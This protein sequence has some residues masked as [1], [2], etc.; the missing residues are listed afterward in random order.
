MTHSVTE[1]LRTLLAPVVISEGMELV[2]LEYKKEGKNWYLRIF[3]DKEGGITME[4]CS[5]ISGQINPLLDVEDAVPHPYILEVSS[6]GLDRPLKKLSDYER[7]AGKLAKIQTFAPQG[8]RKK[9]FGRI[10]GVEGEN[11]L[12][13]IEAERQQVSIPLKDIAKGKLEL[14][15]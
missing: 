4:D 11:V 12:L 13:N 9:F 10:K 7:F 1:N 8:G 15:F 6:P 2:D 14:E 3:I 5:L